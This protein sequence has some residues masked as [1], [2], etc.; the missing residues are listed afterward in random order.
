MNTS[1]WLEIIVISISIIFIL[2]LILTYIYRKRHHLPVGD[3]AYCKKKDLL[4]EYRKMYPKKEHE[5]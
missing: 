4:K 5:N 2:S 1:P 3:C